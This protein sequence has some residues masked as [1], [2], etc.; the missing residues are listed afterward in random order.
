MG[1]ERSTGELPGVTPNGSVH[2]GGAQVNGAPVGEAGDDWRGRLSETL[3]FARRQVTGEGEVDEFGFDPEFNT[4]LL[5][6]LARVLYQ[7][8]FRVEMRGL[9]HVPSTG[10][11][12]LVANH[13]GVLPFDAIMLQTGL[14]DEHPQHR[15]IRLLGADLVYEL[16]GLA[17]LARRAGPHPGLSRERRPPAP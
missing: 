4:R 12:L 16:P 14:H 9:E 8:W 17:S 5:I 10:G 6:P 7:Q 11:A 13:S 1:W 15:N 3:R 2:G